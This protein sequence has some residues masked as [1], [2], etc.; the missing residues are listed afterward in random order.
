MSLLLLVGTHAAAAGLGA[1]VTY[2]VVRRTLSAVTVDGHPAIELHQEPHVSTRTPTWPATLFV[3]LSIVLV[4]VGAQAWNAQ[5]QQRV[6]DARDRAY[7]DCLTGFASD[8]VETLEARSGAYM[9]EQGAKDARD[10][11]VDNV[12]YTVILTR[13]H[14]PAA[15]SR[16]LTRALAAAA[17][18]RA[19]LDVV[20]ERSAKVRAANS[21]VLP[22]AVCTR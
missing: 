14:P 2:L 4:A 11:A 18:A 8:L 9:R 7:A 1:L 3:V 16:D 13:K 21:Y 6:R 17:K 10:R 15:S 12:V 5:H 20:A 19:H 22:Q